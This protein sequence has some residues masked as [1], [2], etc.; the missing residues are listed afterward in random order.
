MCFVLRVLFLKVMKTLVTFFVG[1][2]LLAVPF[3]FSLRK[4]KGITYEAEALLF[5]TGSLFRF[6][7]YRTLFE[8]EEFQK[9][10]SGILSE[11]VTKTGIRI[12][13]TEE[14]PQQSLMV[15]KA[16]GSAKNIVATVANQIASAFVAICD[17]LDRRDLQK[18]A[19]L[20]DRVSAKNLSISPVVRRGL[21][22][23]KPAVS[24]R[25]IRTGNEPLEVALGTGIAGLFGG[26]LSVGL[27]S[28]IAGRKSKTSE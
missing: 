10:V 17:E 23:V 7:Y 20:A 15:V 5:P 24:P 16:G 13:L 1:F 14:M 21:Q 9:E 12:S 26:F 2:F 25:T 18:A 19:E 27:L 4:E 22:V 3:G 28:V 8:G 11:S 6:L